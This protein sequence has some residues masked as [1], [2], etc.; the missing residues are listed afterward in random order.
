MLEKKKMQ[1]SRIG[2]VVSSAI[3][4]FAKF[5]LASRLDFYFNYCPAELKNSMWSLTVRLE[6]FTLR[7]DG[8]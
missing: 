1:E 5:T 4:S 3:F 6:P 8:E 2:G 7:D